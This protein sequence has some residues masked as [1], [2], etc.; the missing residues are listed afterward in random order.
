[1]ASLS[2]SDVVE[3]TADEVKQSSLLL[4]DDVG[5]SATSWQPFSQAALHLELNAEFRV[6][7]SKIAV[8]LK[9][10][11]LLATA[12]GETLTRLARSNYD[13][14][15]NAAGETQIYFVL[16]CD[17]A[18][19]PHS[20]DLGELTFTH[21]ASEVTYRNIDDGILAYPA[22][23]PTSGSLEILFE[24]EVAGSSGNIANADT[25]DDVAVELT[26][27]LSG[28]TITSYA[29]EVS[30]TD[31]ESDDRLRERCMLRWARNLARLGLIDEGVKASALEAAPAVA[32]VAVNSTNP[33][34]QGTFDVYVAGLDT[35]ASAQDVSDVQLAIDLQTFGRNNTPKTCLVYA[36]PEVALDITGIVYYTGATE[37]VVSA[38]VEAA[39]VAFV[40]ATPCGDYSYSPGP[41]NVVALNDLE[42]VIRVA[43]ASVAS[44]RST[45]QLTTPSTSVA[46]TQYGKVV[47]GTWSLTYA[48]INT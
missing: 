25:A 31:E 21:T 3:L 19:G 40:R 22:T 17:A 30:G 8:F 41:S 16:A 33:R 7:S 47:R 4:L 6:E 46:V 24:A 15:R 1:M 11:F 45:V 29:L 35:T 42:S 9:E 48:E 26:T 14:E 38:A 36:A 10:A 13:I 20:I 34:G 28:V 2:Y 37:A 5:F 44:S 27:S 18:N 12:T 39:L 43:V 32:T 23:L